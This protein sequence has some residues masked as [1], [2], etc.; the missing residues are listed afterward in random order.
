MDAQGTQ[1]TYP[2]LKKV[3]DSELKYT[4]ELERVFLIQMGGFCY[5]NER[6]PQYDNQYP[7]TAISKITKSL[8]TEDRGLHPDLCSAVFNALRRHPNVSDIK[9]LSSKIGLAWYCPQCREVHRVLPRKLLYFHVNL[10]SRFSKVE[11]LD[12]EAEDQTS[13]MDFNVMTDSYEYFTIQEVNDYVP[14]PKTA[15]EYSY[16]H[17]EQI[18]KETSFKCNPIGP[19]PLGLGLF[20]VFAK[21]RGQQEPASY[22]KNAQDTIVVLHNFEGT[23]ERAFQTL[24]ELT[25]G[26]L[27]TFY[28]EC[29]SRYELDAMKKEISSRFRD[30]ANQ[31]VQLYEYPKR[32]VLKTRTLVK[33][34][35]KELTNLRKMIV[36]KDAKELELGSSSSGTH[37][38]RITDIDKSEAIFQQHSDYLKHV[39]KSKYHLPSSIE[40]SLN[41]FEEE[42]R[43]IDQ[44]IFTVIV[45]L[46]A[47]AAGAL[48]TQLLNLIF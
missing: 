13:N 30:L 40:Q 5:S 19:T 4:I 25:R 43:T 18:D 26:T 15:A 48:V 27:H 29:M 20:L 36:E 16:I 32:S 39:L 2:N 38:I 44:N 37:L 8:S 41:Q 1:T 6:L 22:I 23:N 34:E 9:E 31:L 11:T 35:R 7:Y 10:P 45:A 47:A 17:E 33:K 42:F 21:T 46:A 12:K 3:L 14:D 28:S 24:Y